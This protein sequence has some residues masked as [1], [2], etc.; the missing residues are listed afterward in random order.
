MCPPASVS[1]SDCFSRPTLNPAQ[2]QV[3]PLHLP[4]YNRS[5]AGLDEVIGEGLHGLRRITGLDVLTVVAHEDGL[6][7]LD[8]NDPLSAL[9]AKIK[10]VSMS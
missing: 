9:Y 4:N 2:R 8:D 6:A 1:I 10:S 5:V 3:Q 7:G